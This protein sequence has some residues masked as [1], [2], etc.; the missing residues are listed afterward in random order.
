MRLTRF[1]VQGFKNF[2]RPVV[3][4]GLDGFDVIHGEN[5]VGK[6]NLLQ[7]I[8]LFFWILTNL[9]GRSVS[10][11]ASSDHSSQYATQFVVE[12]VVRGVSMHVNEQPLAVRHFSPDAIFNFEEPSPIVLLGQISIAPGDFR[13][14]GQDSSEE[15]LVD[16]MVEL[17]RADQRCV[18]VDVTVP[19]N[20][21]AGQIQADVVLNLAR[22]IARDFNLRAES[23]P[24][25]FIL[26]DTLRRVADIDGHSYENNLR[27]T[28]PH[29]LLLL[30]YDAKESVEPGVF[31]R[32]ELFERAMNSLGPVVGD[33]RF[34]ITYNRNQ[35]RAI[36]A[37]QRGSYRIPIEALGSGV[38]QVAS[39]LAR[40]LVANS[41]IVAV[42]EPELNLRYEMQLRLRDMLRDIVASGEGPQQIIVT[43]HSPAFEEGPTFYAMRATEDGPVVERRP[44]SE[45]AAFLQLGDVRP[46]S[47]EGAAYGYVSSEG[48]LRLSDETREQLGVTNGGGVVVLKRPE[49]EFVEILSN[50]Q[51]MR[52]LH[53]DG[54]A[55]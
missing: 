42:E 6:S 12:G 53:G 52:L 22:F 26:V 47:S 18:N 43:S 35:S 11:A 2:R 29:E 10:P 54:E 31:R 40:V 3:L 23:K 44:V 1:E 45:A 41:A 5:N 21:A 32:W 9:G 50:D 38:Q 25:G 13:R 7:A 8:D 51:F 33:G 39:L 19:R 48:L 49:S 27:A 14:V 37:L 34:V 4:E 30:L 20:S 16:V 15:V 17:R 24:H 28:V 36:L 46:P 55:S